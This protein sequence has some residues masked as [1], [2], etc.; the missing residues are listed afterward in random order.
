MRFATAEEMTCAWEAGDLT[1]WDAAAA[2]EQ[3]IDVAVWPVWLAVLPSAL[4]DQLEL[5]NPAEPGP[6]IR[7]RGGS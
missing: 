4:R 3:E 1:P 2:F 5:I 6:R 7:I